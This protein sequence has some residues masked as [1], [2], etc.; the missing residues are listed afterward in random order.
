MQ[1]CTDLFPFFLLQ[2]QS[3]TSPE[4]PTYRMVVD[5]EL[6]PFQQESLDIV[7]SSLR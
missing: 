7:V 4:V 1:E 3:E 5:E 6:L 2:R